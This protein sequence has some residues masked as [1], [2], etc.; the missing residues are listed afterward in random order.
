[1]YCGRDQDKDKESQEKAGSGN[2]EERKQQRSVDTAWRNGVVWQVTTP[3][4][5]LGSGERRRC[6]GS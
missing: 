1:M 6:D 4:T 2:V 3:Y 5:P